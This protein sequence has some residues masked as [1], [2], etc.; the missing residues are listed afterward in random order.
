VTEQRGWPYDPV[1]TSS[2]PAPV[3]EVPV[4]VSV[5]DPAAEEP[6][7]E[8][9]ARPTAFI[10]LVVLVTVGVLL[11][12]F[13]LF[14]WYSRNQELDVLLDR[15]ERAESSQQSGT[16]ERLIRDCYL[17]GGECDVSAIQAAATRALPD[18]RT[19][20]AAVA[21][22]RLPRYHGALRDLRDRYV[23]HNLAWQAWLSSLATGDPDLDLPYEIGVTFTDA[24]VAARR[25]VPPLP[26]HDSRARVDRIFHLT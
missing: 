15:I 18:L 5:Q 24:G 1:D 6:A 3:V 13:A 7:V 19:T 9:P 16:F 11:S 21:E 2:W 25:A 22:M 26:L 8:P 4:V 14:D 20:G 12:A 17:A 10:A 23:E